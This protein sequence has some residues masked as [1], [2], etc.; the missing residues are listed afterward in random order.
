MK[1]MTSPIGA[2][3]YYER[4]RLGRRFCTSRRIVGRQRWGRLRVSPDWFPFH[5]RRSVPRILALFGADF[6]ED[7]S[8]PAT[9]QHQEPTR[10]MMNLFTRSV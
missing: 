7:E 5:Y 4:D 9:W 3:V 6:S 1:R 2:Q 8:L 10:L